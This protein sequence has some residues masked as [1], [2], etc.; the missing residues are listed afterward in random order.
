[1]SDSRLLTFNCH[2]A[3]VHQL[4]ALGRPLDIID[5]LPGRY[6]D[7]WDTRMRP[8]PDGARLVTLEQVRSEALS[9]DCIIGHSLTDLF[10]VKELAAPR[11]LMLHVSLDHRLQQAQ[12]DEPPAQLRASIERYLDL[13]GGVAVAVTKM[14]ADSWGLGE[15]EVVESAADPSD[16]LPWSGHQAAGLRIANQ[17]NSRRE[18]LHW[19]FHEASFAELPVRIVGHNPD[20]PGVEPARD[21]SDLKQLL[22]AHRFFIHTAGPQLEDGFN[23]ALMEAL[24]A[25]LPVIGNRHHSSPITHDLNGLLSDDPLELASHAQRLLTDPKLAARLSAAARQLASDRFSPARFADGLSAA[26]SKA[27][28]KWQQRPQCEETPEPHGHQ[29]G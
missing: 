8:V 7:H 27:S 20:M 14:K 21:W 25:G 26:I 9:Y 10:A 15:C 17:I 3:W 4:G 16:Y 11:V 23:M 29:S 5:G 22:S 6:I 13:V 19:D 1:M 2:E 28:E 24:A 12:M 18:Y